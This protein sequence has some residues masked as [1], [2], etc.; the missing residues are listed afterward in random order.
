VFLRMSTTDCGNR[1]KERKKKENIGGGKTPARLKNGERA[2][3]LKSEKIL[4][5]ENRRKSE[6]WVSRKNRSN[7][8]KG[9]LILLGESVKLE[10]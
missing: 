10:S 7:L 6:W 8:N 2:G 3:T 9:R 4:V 5:Q 1:A